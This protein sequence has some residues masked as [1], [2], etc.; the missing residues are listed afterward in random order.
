MEYLKGSSEVRKL[1]LI[2]NSKLDGLKKS[3][4]IRIN[5]RKVTDP[6]KAIENSKTFLINFFKSKK[7][8]SPKSQSFFMKKEDSLDIDTNFDLKLAKLITK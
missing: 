3:Q 5:E 2:G 8:I 1:L 7:L 4:V 6:Y